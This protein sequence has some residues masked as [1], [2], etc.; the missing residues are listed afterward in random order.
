[1]GS[2]HDSHIAKTARTRL[3]W[4]KGT[5]ELLLQIRTQPNR[6]NQ[7]KKKRKEKNYTAT[8]IYITRA[9]MQSSS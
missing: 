6:T 3:K 9:M 8:T 7:K 2:E 4:E 5:D 1:M